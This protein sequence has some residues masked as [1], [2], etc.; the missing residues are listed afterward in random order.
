MDQ[1]ELINANHVQQCV[2]VMNIQFWEIATME[3]VNIVE[4]SKAVLYHSKF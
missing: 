4:I 3:V 2:L 1:D